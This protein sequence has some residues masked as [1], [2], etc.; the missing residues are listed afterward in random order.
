MIR[1]AVLAG[2]LFAMTAGAASL[3]SARA[4]VPFAFELSGKTLPAGNYEFRP[5]DGG[6]IMTVDGPRGRTLVAIVP[7]SVPHQGGEPQLVFDKA[8]SQY[9][10]KR[11]WMN[12]F[13]SG[14]EIPAPKSAKVA[15]SGAAS[16]D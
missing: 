4:T 15:K 5:A 16:V 10:L 3:G 14:A 2:S 13:A 7:A 8:G 1:G 6:N 11:V 12:G 9:I